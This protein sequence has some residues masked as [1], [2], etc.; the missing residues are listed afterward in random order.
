MSRFI[1]FYMLHCTPKKCN[2]ATGGKAIK[3]KTSTM[4]NKENLYHLT[5]RCATCSRVFLR[6]ER[7]HFSSRKRKAQVR[8]AAVSRK[9]TVKYKLSLYQTQQEKAKQKAG[10]LTCFSFCVTTTISNL[11][12]KSYIKTIQLKSEQFKQIICTIKWPKSCCIIRIVF[13]V[14]SGTVMSYRCN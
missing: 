9:P 7:A 6:S 3:Q 13:F 2:K 4:H 5:N 14:I 10:R 11:Y 12:Q 8:L 1:R